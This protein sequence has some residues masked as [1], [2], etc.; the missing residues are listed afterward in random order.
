MPT[1]SPLGLQLLT[2]Y[3]PP[4]VAAALLLINAKLKP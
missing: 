4:T 1:W 3:R 2:G